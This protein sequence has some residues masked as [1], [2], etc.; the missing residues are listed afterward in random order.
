[1]CGGKESY[2]LQLRRLSAVAETVL[3]SWEQEVPFMSPYTNM[4]TLCVGDNIQERLPG[5]FQAACYLQIERCISA[6][7]CRDITVVRDSGIGDTQINLCL[8]IVDVIVLPH[9]V[10]HA[11]E[12][13]T[14]RE[15]LAVHL[16]PMQCLYSIF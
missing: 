14:P 1:M 13:K 4:M 2:W 16:D 15:S 5:C 10:G 7:S 12:H 6:G 8:Y 9:F 11:R 3:G